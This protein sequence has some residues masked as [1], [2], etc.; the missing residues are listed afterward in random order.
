MSIYILSDDEPQ[1]HDLLMLNAIPAYV[2]AGN[3]TQSIVY[4]VKTAWDLLE[5]DVIPT[6]FFA[7]A[8]FTSPS[9]PVSTMRPGL[10][11]SAFV[12]DGDAVGLGACAS[13]AVDMVK[14][15]KTNAAAIF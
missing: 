8:I 14:N 6:G 1:V 11:S 5:I 12:T 9:N 7:D 10:I 4:H 15:K 13:S 2:L 3:H